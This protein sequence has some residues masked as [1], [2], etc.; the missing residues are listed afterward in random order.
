[1]RKKC[2]TFFNSDFLADD[3][4]GFNLRLRLS[5][6]Q[7]G[8]PH[9]AFGERNNALGECS[10]MFLRQRLHGKFLRWDTR[11]RSNIGCQNGP[12]RPQGYTA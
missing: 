2:G 1:M 8:L 11:L 5:V 6:R 9:D 10:G 3:A 4:Q 7:H 12:P